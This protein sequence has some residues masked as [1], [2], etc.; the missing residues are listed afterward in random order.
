M[1]QRNSV[2]I[3]LATSNDSYNDIKELNIA[4]YEKYGNDGRT[5]DDEY[6]IYEA[7]RS[8]DPNRE[9]SLGSG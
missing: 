4:T 7:R 2:I 9:S 6:P 3:K 5:A 8:N 1:L